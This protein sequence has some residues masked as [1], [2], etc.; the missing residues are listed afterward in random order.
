[1]AVWDDVIDFDSVGNWPM[2]LTGWLRLLD[3]SAD[4]G[5]RALVGERVQRTCSDQG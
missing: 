1:M 2:E 4:H 3:Q 5:Q